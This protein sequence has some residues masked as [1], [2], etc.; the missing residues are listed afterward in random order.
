M[1]VGVAHA[2]GRDLHDRFARSRVGDG[3]IDQLDGCPLGAGDDSLD[4]LRHTKLLVAW[5][6][7]RTLIR[8]PTLT[9]LPS[10]P[11][12]PRFGVSQSTSASTQSNVFV[13]AFFQ[14]R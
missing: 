8:S 10:P 9:T 5:V 13:T 11:T 6:G 2:A 4:D 14:L 12:A 1:Q 7:E 3:D